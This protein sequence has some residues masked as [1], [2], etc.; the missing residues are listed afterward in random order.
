MSQKEK[1]EIERDNLGIIEN[2]INRINE[3]NQEKLDDR[4]SSKYSS[5]L[6]KEKQDCILEIKKIVK[7]I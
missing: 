2:C 5:G 6:D 4:F 3:I 7:G 1:W